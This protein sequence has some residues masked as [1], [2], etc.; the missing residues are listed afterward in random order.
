MGFNMT[1][2]LS[3][4]QLL[5]L[6]ARS[7][8]NDVRNL[9]KELALCLRRSSETTANALTGSRTE[10]TNTRPNFL[11]IASHFTDMRARQI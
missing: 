4:P 2:Y 9:K 1:Q 8:H 11:T 3:G 6:R 5:I 7:L 10:N